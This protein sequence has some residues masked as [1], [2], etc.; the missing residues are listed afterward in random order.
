MNLTP[1][2]NSDLGSFLLAGKTWSEW[3]DEVELAGI[4]AREN[5]WISRKDLSRLQSAGGAAALVLDDEIVATV[6]SGEGCCGE[7]V[8][9][10]EGS[11]LVKYIWDFYLLRYRF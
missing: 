4:S 5:L 2:E 6:G 3:R 7:S 11:F 10:G 1:Y 9:A 8:L